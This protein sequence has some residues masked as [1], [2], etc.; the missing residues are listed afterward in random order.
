MPADAI[1]RLLRDRP[2]IRG[3]AIPGMPI[4]SPGMEVDDRV[5]PY[6]TL[7]FDAE[8]KT[9]VFNQHGTRT[10]APDASAAE[11]PTPAS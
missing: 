10:A 1:H 7:L 4:G 6:Q 8:G 3:L 2:T 5:E 11:V 9:T